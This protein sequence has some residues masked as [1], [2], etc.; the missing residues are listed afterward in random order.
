MEAIIWKDKTVTYRNKNKKVVTEKLKEVYESNNK[1]LKMLVT[2]LDK[3]YDKDY[4]LTDEEW[5]TIKSYKILLDM[6]FNDTE[7]LKELIKANEKNI[8]NL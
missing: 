1:N 7:V 4:Y 5:N 3:W 8:S 2:L 6:C